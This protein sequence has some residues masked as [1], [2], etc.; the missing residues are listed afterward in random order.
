M[1]DPLLV[2]LPAI[3]NSLL[4]G[5]IKVEFA[6]MVTLATSRPVSLA[7]A[8]ILTPV[9]VPFPTVKVPLALAVPDRKVK[10]MS[11][12]DGERFKL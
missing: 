12:A 8:S 4:G 1:K 6:E 10:V 3:V 2:K 11:L 9:L 7:F 5:A